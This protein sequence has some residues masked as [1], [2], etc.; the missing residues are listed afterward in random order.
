MEGLSLW[1]SHVL[2]MASWVS[3]RKV[4]PTII[5]NMYEVNIQ[6]VPSNECDDEDLD[7]VH[8]RCPPLLRMGDMQRTDFTVHDVYV[9]SKVYSVLLKF[10]LKTKQQ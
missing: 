7:L 8:R 9:A 6:S 10:T 3:S 1:S 4:F 2:R 5:E